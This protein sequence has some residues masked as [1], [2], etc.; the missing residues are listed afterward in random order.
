MRRLA[1]AG[2]AAAGVL[3]V[4]SGIA[5][6]RGAQAGS[7]PAAVPN[8]IIYW[9]A[10][11]LAALFVVATA[12]LGWRARAAQPRLAR[13]SLLTGA[14]L[15]AHVALGIAAARLELPALTAVVQLSTALALVAVL[16][17]VA[18]GHAEAAAGPVKAGQQRFRRSLLTAGGAF[19]A[20][21]LVGGLVT[22][23]GATTACGQGFPLCNGTLLPPDLLSLAG[24]QQIHRVSVLIVALLLLSL[25]WQ[26]ARSRWANGTVRALSLALAGSFIGQVAS[27]AAF[28]IFPGAALLAL[29]HQIFGTAAWASLVALALV[30]WHVPGTSRITQAAQPAW[31]QTL[32]DYLKLTKPG[33]ISLLLLTTLATMYIAGSPSLWLVF[34]TMV[35]GYL[36]AGGANAIN[37]YIDRDVDVLMG[38]TARRPI[39]SNRINPTHALIFGVALGVLSFVLMVAFVNLLSAALSLFALLFYVLVY[40]SWLK[41]S[42]TQNIVIGGAAGAIPPMIGWAAVTGDVSLLSLFLFLIVFYWT[43]PHFWALALIRR[44]DYARAGI[45]MLPVVQG[46][47]ETKKQI[48]LYSLIMIA[49]TV[50]PTPLRLLGPIYLVGALVLGGI[51][52]RY[53]MQLMGEAAN[54]SAWKLYRFSLLYLALLFGVMVLDAVVMRAIA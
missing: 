35:G 40:T 20:V 48:L 11:L 33:V 34:W 54:G 17:A 28:V 16:L 7:T 52:M 46:E 49:I 24:L 5:G 2:T 3:A 9:A 42:S 21:M 38:R 31:R 32:N 13:L 41:R 26:L 51:H 43:P 1:L 47:G 18:L 30:A 10:V 19:Y 37:C 25:L 6:M 45:P 15:I 50:L 53:V 4:V 39:P 27:G 36:S 44:D 29:L 14:L 12:V 23:T 22:S 8:G